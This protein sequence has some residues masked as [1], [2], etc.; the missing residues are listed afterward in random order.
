VSGGELFE[1]IVKY[2]T[3][4]ETRT[5]LLMRQMLVA[6]KY[7]HDNGIA[8]RDLKVG[9]ASGLWWTCLPAEWRVCEE[10][11]LGCC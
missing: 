8:H 11:E 10:D 3:V 2:G 1:F 5:R 4:P 7:L 9:I 6:L